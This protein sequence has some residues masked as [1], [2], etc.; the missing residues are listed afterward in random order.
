MARL[1]DRI[2]IVTGGCS[3]IGEEVV[4]QF[5]A[6]GACVVVTDRQQPQGELAG[7]LG[8]RL[9]YVQADITIAEELAR[10]FE[11]AQQRFGGLDILVNNAG[12]GG[13]TARIVDMDV[14]GW[15]AMFALLVRA[16]MLA[17]K[18]GA[19]LMKPRGGGS[20]INVSSIAGLRT[21]LTAGAAY[22]VAKAAALKLTSTAALELAADNI[23]VNAMLP[24]AV[25][26]PIFAGGFG[27][28]QEA[29]RKHLPE[30]EAIY[31]HGQP[32]P[33]TGKPRHLAKTAVF[34]ASDE[35]EFITG[36]DIIVDGG[37]TL[38]PSVWKGAREKMIELGARLRGE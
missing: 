11:T 25:A 3:G 38:D 14:E 10:V 1:P 36:V 22:S 9:C 23:R 28:S 7:R 35:S 5:L 12:A 8:D 29:G 2:A 37:L 18:Y 20:I 24:G 13:T 30:V 26:T 32:L 16:P 34:L 27:L 31:R 21:G 6:E 19:P 4:L 17:I 33:V 15:D